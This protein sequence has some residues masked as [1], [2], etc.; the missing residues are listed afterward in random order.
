MPETEKS[1][2][3]T[4]KNL[5]IS[6]ALAVAILT[7]YAQVVA[8]D[9]INIDDD[10]YIVENPFVS[11]GLNFTNFKWALTAFHAS[12][13][14]P[15]T[16][17]SHQ[18]DASFFG[19]NAGGHH[20]VNVIFHALNSI[21][22]FFLVKK[23]TGAFWKSAIVAAVF[24]VHPAH[25]ESV[26]WVAER[27][28]VLS[29][30]LWL[31]ATWFYI[32]YA[33]N[34]K[35]TNSYWLA[36]LLFALGLAAKPML[37]T[38]PFTLILLDYWALER[39]DKWN[40]QNLL[41]L[42]KEKIPFFALTIA[43]VIITIWAQGTSGAIQSTEVISVGDR[44]QNAVLAYAKYVLMLVYP[45]N[46]G[47]WYPFDNNFNSIQVA[48]SLL[49]LIAITAVCMRQIKTR[50]YL[51]VGWFWFL[52][53]LVPVIGILQV[54]RQALADRYTYVPYIG[55]T[56]AVVW[57]FAEIFERFKLNQKA[58]AAICGI[59]LF[60]L[61]IAAFRQ[62][63]YWRNSETLF[64]RT[65]AVTEKNYFVENN[66]CNYLEKKNRLGEAAAQCQAA[67][68]NEPTLAVAYNTY[69]T[70]LMKQNKLAE[71]RRNFEKTLELDPTYTLAG[72]NLVVLATNQGDIDAAR[73]NLSKAIAADKNNF[74]DSA[75]L[76]DAY[77]SIAVAAM[78]QKRFAA[79]EE[80]FKKAL[81]IAPNNLDFRRNLASALNFQGKSAEA[82]KML[83]DITRQNPNFPEA[84]NTLGLIYAE[85]NRRQ[86]AIAQFQRALQI[87]PNFAPARS[88]LER[89]M[90]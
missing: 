66:F 38:L 15:L 58:I 11:R 60:V 79:A 18:L 53:T 19:L 85:Q 13:W 73:Q 65:L 75:R 51:F 20:V 55:L 41:S 17:L 39:F 35:E 36:L 44:L 57:L 74:F 16:W 88:N 46:L 47:I 84:H 28:D 87:N 77:S 7:I 54:G 32:R 12:N 43:S 22:L 80:F 56:I 25:V 70:V 50:K 68:A 8:F 49:L 26:A 40:F 63:S 9:F 23:L 34:T 10:I 2:Y 90:R 45:T 62:T 76:A 67:I 42:V 5:I 89:A 82:I 21:L 6:L 3:E 72:A 83:E 37:V 61:S 48:A 86:E 64:T 81:E 30:L 27:K 31:G 69:G 4:N 71:A 78:R 24:A 29:T 59:A 14:H 52:G 1:F 33:R